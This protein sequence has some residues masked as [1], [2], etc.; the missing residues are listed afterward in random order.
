MTFV[1]ASHNKKKIK[2]LEALLKTLT[3]KD[4]TI[5]SLDDIGFSGDIDETGTTFEENAM[6]KASVPASMG[7]YGIADDSGLEVDVLDGAPGVYSARYSGENATDELNN[8]KLMNELKDVPYEKRTGR[9]VCVMAIASP[10]GEKS[11]FTV[12]GECDGMII[13]SPRGEN[14]FGYD[15]Y[16]YY[17]PMEM[18]F[19]ELSAEQKNSCSHRAVA[20]K[21]LVEEMKRRNML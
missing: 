9:F 20:V 18:T 4:M 19:A 6:I 16:F 8:Q 15:P 17:E 10:D 2:E 11:S 21:L 7:Y 12:R 5:L 1:L 13:D 3:S 14:G